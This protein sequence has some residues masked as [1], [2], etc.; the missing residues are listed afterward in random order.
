M[1]IIIYIFLLIL[2][3]FIIIELIDNNKRE[4]YTTINNNEY[5]NSISKRTRVYTTSLHFS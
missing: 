2:I 5:I 1:N 4:T 3:L